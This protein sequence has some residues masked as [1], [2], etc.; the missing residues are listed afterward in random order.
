MGLGRALGNCSATAVAEATM[1]GIAGAALMPC[2]PLRAVDFCGVRGAPAGAIVAPAAEPASYERSPGNKPRRSPEHG[3]RARRIPHTLSEKFAGTSVILQRSAVRGTSIL[4]R[5]RGVGGG[6]RPGRHAGDGGLPFHGY[7]GSSGSGS[8]AILRYLEV[9][10]GA[11]YFRVL[12]TAASES[13]M[14][15]RRE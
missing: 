11:C 10:V 1:Q 13:T 8:N 6:G 12:L 3:T 4:L 2:S 7:D 9:S 15:D 5:N 14:S